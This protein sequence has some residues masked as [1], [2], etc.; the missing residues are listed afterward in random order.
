[1]R[2][3]RIS[4]TDRIQRCKR[5]DVDVVIGLLDLYRKTNRVEYLESAC[6]VADNILTDRFHGGLFVEGR[7]YRYTRLDRHEPLA[8]LHLVSVIRDSAFAVPTYWPNQAFF[9]CAYER[10]GR[11]Y[12]S[13]LIY[14][15]RD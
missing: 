4:R 12:D 10:R 13:E 1:M 7:D 8:L 5:T 3:D 2:L 11:R 15:Q 9:A 14:Q 6:Q